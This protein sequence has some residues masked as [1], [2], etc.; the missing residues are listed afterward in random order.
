MAKAMAIKLGL[1][2]ELIDK[3]YTAALFHDI[4]KAVASFQHHI[5]LCMGSL[6]LKGD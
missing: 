5:N 4:G 2:S 1:S 3:S 6:S